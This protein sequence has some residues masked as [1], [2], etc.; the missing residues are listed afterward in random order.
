MKNSNLFLISFLLIMLFCFSNMATS[1][2][3]DTLKSS[4]N[5][6]DMSIKMKRNYIF[7]GGGYILYSSSNSHKFSNGINLNFKYLHTY[8][9][10]FG[11]RFDFDYLFANRQSYINSES[12]FAGVTRVY[13][14]NSGNVS[15]FLLKINTVFG[16]ISPD[17]TLQ[18]YVF[19]GLGIGYTSTTA[20]YKMYIK[21]GTSANE[22]ITDASHN[23][24]SLGVSAG[25]GLNVRVINS[26]RIFTEVQANAWYTG[27]DGPSGFNAVKL[28]LVF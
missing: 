21:G 25:I 24:I 3:S 27:Y 6:S 13:D 5:L 26:L 22:P 17:N 28:G 14:Y 7:I 12:D 20:K 16:S 1:L 4:K 11:L 2:T 15:S 8:N 10:A 19:P 9:E 23:N 18:F